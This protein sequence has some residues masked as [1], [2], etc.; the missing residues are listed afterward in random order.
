MTGFF[1]AILGAIA[2]AVFTYRYHA[3]FFSDFTHQPHYFLIVLTVIPLGM[4][5]GAAVLHGLA[6]G[7]KDPKGAVS[8]CRKAILF[9]W[10]Y[11]TGALYLLYRNNGEELP[12][13]FDLALLLLRMALLHLPATLAI[14]LVGN[15]GLYW[16]LRAHTLAKKKH[17]E[18]SGGGK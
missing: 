10:L 17:K 4:A 2:I 8:A 9:Q 3:L 14:S 7:G 16:N 15:L 11:T 13:L 1:G 5:A 18:Q 6:H 12:T